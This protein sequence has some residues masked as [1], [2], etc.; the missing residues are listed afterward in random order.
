MESPSAPAP[1]PATRFLPPLLIAAVT[2]ATFLPSFRGEF[3]LWDDDI[4]FLSN[5]NYRGLRLEN[6]RWM[7]T[8][9]AGHYMPLTWLTLGLD[10]VLWVM[11]PR[12]YHATNLILHGFN[13]ALCYL[14]LRKLLGRAAPDLEPGRAVLAASVGALL[15]SIHP[16]RVESVAWITERRD[17][18]SGAFF[19]LTILAWLR[20]TEA[21]EGSPV[22][23]TW[24]IVSALLFAAML[25]SKTM[26]LSLPLVLLVLDVYPLRRF[27]KAAAP[28]L[29]LEKIPMFALMVAGLAMIAVSATK[30]GGMS[31]RAHYPLIQ[32]LG[33]PGFALTFYVAKTLLPVG[34]SPLYWYRPELGVAHVVGWVILLALSAAALLGRRRW[35]AVLAAW[36]SYGLLIAPASG[37]LSLGSFYA[38]DHYT[39]VGCLPFS[40][41][42]AAAIVALRRA[43]LLAT[44][45]VA[46]AMLLAC[47]VASASYCRVWQ[48]SV[49]LWT[50]AIDLEPDVY[51]SYAHRGQAYLARR[52]WDRAIADLDRAIELEPRFEYPWI[53]RA[54]ARLNRGDPSG[55]AADASVAL[56][57]KPDNMEARIDRALA[58]A[59]IG[60]F[61]GALADYDEVIRLRPAPVPLMR[62]AGLRG[63][64]GNLDGA[65]ADAREAIRLKPDLYEAYVPLGGALLARGDQ[66]GAAQAFARALELAPPDW[67]QRRQVEQFLREA[68]VPK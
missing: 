66:D 36:V 22:R 12:G 38:A 40:A 13:A 65:I 39:Y 30:A 21:P 26:G 19:L 56:Q 1:R 9:Y 4:N 23:R 64:I 15:F 53:Y 47:G 50:R 52:Q 29:L 58:R 27:S 20:M 57:L 18:L 11:D 33:R 7:F 63:M 37:L 8:D 32:S 68:R 28:R 24:M 41:L 3:L 31:D 5:P 54:Q 61:S 2:V 35:P 10:Y 43:P 46:G 60:D 59:L 48:D 16:L 51:F 42:A 45:G 17:L 49:S 67:P 14:L 44:A 55:A 6:L 62:R 25:L 34:L